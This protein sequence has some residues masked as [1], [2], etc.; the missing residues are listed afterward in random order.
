MCRALSVLC[1][2]A[3]MI[4]VARGGSVS[5]CNQ[6]QACCPNNGGARHAIWQSGK[7]LQDAKNICGTTL[8]NYKPKLN[9]GSGS[10][11]VFC[12][13]RHGLGNGFKARDQSY[14]RHFGLDREDDTIILAD[15]NRAFPQGHAGACTGADD[16]CERTYNYKGIDGDNELTGNNCQAKKTVKCD[17]LNA[18]TNRMKVQCEVELKGVSGGSDCVL[19]ATVLRL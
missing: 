4:A 7:A 13:T 11:R 19:A 18:W 15:A 1:A 2:C 9:G 16:S 8:N 3:V 17:I 6:N 14:K 12:Q 10:C 5:S